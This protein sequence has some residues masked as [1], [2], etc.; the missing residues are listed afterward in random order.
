MAILDK[1]V[2]LCSNAIK[3]PSERE[4]VLAELT[5]AKLNKKAREILEISFEEVG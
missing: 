4:R 3:D 2:V 5:D 1:H